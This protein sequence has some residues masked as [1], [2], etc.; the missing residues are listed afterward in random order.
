MRPPSACV[1]ELRTWDT[2]TFGFFAKRDIFVACAVGLADEIKTQDLYA[3]HAQMVTR[4]LARLL[5][6]EDDSNSDVEDLHT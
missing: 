1:V 3:A 4:L 2:R 5:P 6:T